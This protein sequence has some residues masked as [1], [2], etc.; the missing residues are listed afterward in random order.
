MIKPVLNNVLVKPFPADE[1]SL[2]GIY[3][4]ETS[5]KDSNKVLIVAIGSGTK[6][7]PMLLKN[8]DVGYRV[9]DH[10]TEIIDN[11]EKFYL[12]SQDAI[13]ALND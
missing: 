9:K 7:K 2:G 13:I 11:G 8:G 6:N 12:L 4:P 1:I 5:R 10:G 3:V